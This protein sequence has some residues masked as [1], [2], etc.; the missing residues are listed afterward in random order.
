MKTEEKR[1][2]IKS[3]MILVK[4]GAHA[5]FVCPAQTKEKHIHSWLMEGQTASHFLN[6]DPIEKAIK[7]RTNC[8]VDH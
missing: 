2:Q 5:A 6:F 7:Q 8:Y 3:L 1:D 4:L